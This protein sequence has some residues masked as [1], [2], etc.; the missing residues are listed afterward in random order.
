MKALLTCLGV[1][2]ALGL[3]THG[4]FAQYPSPGLPCAPNI[5]GYPIRTAPDLCG[6]YFYCNNG[7]NWFGPSYNVVPPFPPVGGVMPGPGFP[8]GQAQGPVGFPYN[9][10]T[11]S[12]RDFFMWN[13]A[14]QERHTR[15]QRLPYAPN[16]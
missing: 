14:Q 7:C 1:A 9:P 3:A 6:S 12:P 15:E 4:A 10:W 8:S 11:R 13:E 2:T 16:Y 5:A